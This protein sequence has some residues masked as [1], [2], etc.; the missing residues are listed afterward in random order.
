M[1]NQKYRKEEPEQASRL[2]RLLEARMILENASAQSQ[3]RALA[4]Q[5][6][7]AAA[8]LENGGREIDSQIEGLM[9]VIEEGKIYRHQVIEYDRKRAEFFAGTLMIE[10][11]KPERPAISG[12]TM[13]SASRQLEKL[14]QRAQALRE[15][16]EIMVATTLSVQT[17][18]KRTQAQS[19]ETP[20]AQTPPVSMS[21]H[22]EAK[23]ATR[24]H[25]AATAAA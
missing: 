17:A 7:L 13:V 3:E 20:Q 4:I 14:A 15:D 23:F 5:Q 1:S 18:M 12:A 21:E 22:R 10:P 2:D 24:D 8:Y 9:L 6:A 19:T 11:S 16:V 25:R